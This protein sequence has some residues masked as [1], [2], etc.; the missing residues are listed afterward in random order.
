V[1]GKGFYLVEA[2]YA[3]LRAYTVVFVT[4]LAIVTKSWPG[5]ILAFVANRRSGAPVQKCAL[6]VSSDK[7]EVGRLQTDDQGLAE[8][9]LEEAKPE[10][11]LVLAQQGEDFA[12]NSLYSWYL[13]SDPERYWVGYVYSDRP[14]YRPGHTVYFRGIL[15]TQ[16]GAGYRLPEAREVQV[17]ILDPE[18]KPVYR[19]A[20]P[21]SSNGTIHGE[22]S[23][24]AASA[25]GYYS[26]EVRAGEARVEGGFNVEEYKK[27]E[28][29][30]KLVSAR[31]RV[32]QGE[33]IDAAIEAR[34]YF[35][36]PVAN[37]KVTYV[38]HRS[39]FWVP[40]YADEEEEFGEEEE[41]E[42]YYYGGEQ[43]LEEKGQLDAEGRLTVKIPTSVSDRKWDMRYRIEARV[44]DQ[45]NREIAGFTAVPATYG[46][47]MVNIRPEQYVYQAG[48][49]ARFLIEARDY[50]GKAIP[51]AVSVE[52]F[53]WRWR[54]KEEPAIVSLMAQTDREGK[55]KVEMPVSE[56]GSFSARVRARTPE[57]REVEDRAYV[58][59]SG[60]LPA[61]YQ[62]R[63]DRIEIVPDKKSY[64]PGDVAKVLIVTGVP[65]AYILLT[66]EGHALH[67]RQVIRASASTVT[68]DVPIRSEYAPNFYL[69]ATFLR[70]HQLYQGSKSIKVPPIE[71]QLTVEV[72]SSKS[73]YKPG[74]P[75]VFNVTARDYRGKPVSAEF[76]LG[77]VDEAIYAV[78]P[79]VVRDILKF[80]YGQAYNRVDTD[81]SL[82]YYFQGVAG[83]R[84][85]AL[86]R[87][88][89]GGG[90]ATSA[91]QVSASP[92]LAQLKPERLVEPRVRK[93]FP[94]T[95]FWVANLTTDV[96]GRAQARFEFPDAL[97]TWR[98]TARGVTR[99]TKVGN[100]IYRTQVR[101]NLMLRLAVPR[102]FTQG[103]EVTV[104]A[105]VHNYLASEKTAR[106][107]L[108][109]QGLEV[110]A[111]ATRDVSIPSRGEAHIDWR[112]RA[113]PAREAKLLG[114][115]LT[116]EESDAMELT[117][118][119][120]PYG[121]KLSLARGGA[122]AEPVAEFETELTFP[123]QIEPTS[124]ALE[125]SVSPSL[126]GAIFGALEYLTSYPYGC[127]E[128]TMSSFLPN[129]VVA[130]ALKELKL[131]SN[132]DE[133]GLEKKIRA[134]LDRLYDYQ[135]EDGGWG[136]WQTDE[137]GAFMT[138]YVLAG[139]AQAKTAGYPVKDDVINRGR[140][141]LRA[142]FDRERR[143]LPDLR[144]YLAYA[145]VHTGV[146]DRTVLDAIWEKRSDLTAYGRAL[147][148]LAMDRLGDTRAGELAEQ[149]E[150]QAKVDER[151][152]YWALDRDTLM[153][154][155]GDASPE[156][157]AYAMKLLTHLRP[158]SPLLPKAALWLVNHRNEGY[159][160]YSTKQTAM[161]IYGLTDYLKASGELKPNFTVTVW[162]N[163]KQVLS[164]RFAEADA[165]SVTA[166]TIRLPAEGLALAGNKIRIRKS[167]EGTLYWTTRADYYSTEEKL[168][169][170]GKVALNLLREYFKLVPVREEERIVYRL[171]SL[172]ETL[173][174]GDVIVTRLT[175][176]GGNW[177]YLMVE[178]PIPA[179][180]E[181]I[182]RDD[183]YELKDKPP[184]WYY[185]F[186]RREFHDDRAAFFQTYFNGGQ[187]QYLYLLKVVNP[188]RFRVSPAR[189]QPMYQPQYLATTES[190]TVEVK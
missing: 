135:H 128:Q 174:P 56:A 190:K 34:Y 145:L 166:P 110:L 47:F 65:E 168:Q 86:A 16:V 182:E 27:P 57:G 172:P 52:L 33:P 184:W 107:S 131:K 100:T 177:R 133:A 95:A 54:E 175:V 108:A 121:V 101:K 93:A 181:F 129:I 155:Y 81:S 58:W 98:A 96:N 19:K 14:V 41:G 127:T 68:V 70:D 66:T 123:Q 85:M 89:G 147:L 29:E 105:L 12:A 179:G 146:Q 63:R 72:E 67:T 91:A 1:P 69:S 152:A 48:D 82:S 171:E 26:I 132:L 43:I 42:G 113:Q 159:Y 11:V 137:S 25:L 162:V 111:G 64:R 164:Q 178:D 143:A 45:S 167:G 44:T 165:L 130:Q 31:K 144:A 139:L 20:V 83:K 126:A 39:R 170:L 122:V 88:M 4:D 37:A 40:F 3:D 99:D 140:G 53:R 59:V 22:F 188:G 76:S 160:W 87:L 80:F 2:V 161:V 115:A 185:W 134:G 141:W 78:Q 119:V 149:L 5:H 102:F 84:A 90:L 142:A 46:S 163:D 157:T 116:D 104:S 169:R 6:F 187:T 9:R 97:T 120:I 112:V 51:T 17:E 61:W 114:K 35:G 176:S 189:V 38:V 136:W 79:E 186:T 117:L 106:V 125:L 118:P 18:N 150:A 50:D 92:D 124:R 32:L 62:T 7:K 15:R 156:A 36:E 73:E 74:E 173:Q 55:A 71:Q 23:L 49:T 28:F 13:S 153:D 94:D 77:V 154:F 151:E 10:N 24:S 75:A 138:A 158:K 109:V 60:A 30:V 183:L 103:D 8:A 148:G 21:V 180:T